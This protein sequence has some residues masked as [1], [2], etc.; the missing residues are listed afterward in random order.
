MELDVIVLG[1]TYAAR[2]AALEAA[3]RDARV[4][5]VPDA[6]ERY[7]MHSGSDPAWESMAVATRV[8]SAS[9]E[10][11][12]LRR[13]TPCAATRND[14]SMER[15]FRSV[16]SLA[17]RIDASAR[18]K[19]EARGV[20]VMP[21]VGVKFESATRLR[22]RSGD[23]LTA[24][25]IILATGDRPRRPSRFVFDERVV[26]DPWTVLLAEGIPRS[27]V[28]VGGES[29]GCQTACLFAALGTTVT[30]IDR[31]QRCLRYVDRDVLER[32]H[33]RMQS[34]GIEL[35]L[36]ECLSSLEVCDP[37]GERHVRA[38]LTSGRVEICD[39]LVVA[40]GSAPNCRG[41]DLEAA[42][43][44]VDE[45]G[46]VQVDERGRTSQP[47]VYAAGGVVS[48][49]GAMGEA[50]FG[51]AVVRE[52][53]GIGEDLV[54]VVPIG[55]QTIP[56]IAMV[57]V[58]DEVCERLDVPWVS[59]MAD[60]EDW[61]LD[62]DSSLPGGLLKLVVH[63]KTGEVLGVHVIG[64]GAHEIIHLG[65]WIVQVGGRLTDIARIPFCTGSVSDAY[66]RA[67]IACVEEMG[68]APGPPSSPPEARRW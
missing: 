25:V 56:E 57:G 21:D 17:S 48:G 58:T 12:H 39:R 67:A 36:G 44:L 52:A 1:W 35:I 59:G 47:G 38:H 46:F 50:Q 31:R 66:R 42:A 15:V 64:R 3:R 11:D 8:A 68:D 49:L 14:T 24:P 22:S 6:A 63:R 27:M 40:A 54:Q 37:S 62:A 61:Q 60:L 65:T 29:I 45:Q 55:I 2:E 23:V 26:F 28:V 30:I 34:A 41:L 32:L 9:L 19:L 13:M 4:L 7:P 43:I 10:L 5:L 33:A 53:M 20:L 16:R 18:A 51:R